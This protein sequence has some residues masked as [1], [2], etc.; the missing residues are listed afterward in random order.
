MDPVHVQPVQ[1]LTPDPR[2]RARTVV[3]VAIPVVLLVAYVAARVLGR[4]T[5]GPGARFA[6]VETPD[7]ASPVR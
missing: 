6:A 4:T 1:S 7:P 3:A 2:S 5:A